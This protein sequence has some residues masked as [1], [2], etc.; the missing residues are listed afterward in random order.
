MTKQEFAKYMGKLMAFLL[1][2]CLP[3]VLLIGFI[4]FVPERPSKAFCIPCI[5][6]WTCCRIP[7]A[8]TV[9]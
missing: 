4:G 6:S 7:P 8:A 9:S 2:L 3:F 1:A 5:I